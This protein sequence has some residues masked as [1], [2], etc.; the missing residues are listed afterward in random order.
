M[1]RRVFQLP[2]TDRDF[3]DV[4]YPY[5]EAIAEGQSQWVI[6]DPFE[7]AAGFNHQKVAVALRITPT[8]PDTE[9][10][11]AY[12]KPNLARADG[13]SIRALSTLQMDGQSWQQW[14]RHRVSGDW[15][16]GIDNLETHLLYVR[17]FLE[18]ELKK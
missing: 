17:S 2:E 11:M 10:D 3:L 13:K 8:Y 1:A 9:I 12:F 18:L 16:P 5:W 7:V 14:S 4:A 15:R 6:L